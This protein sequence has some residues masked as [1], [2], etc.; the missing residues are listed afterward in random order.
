MTKKI[1]GLIARAVQAL[2]YKGAAA[3]LLN[4]SDPLKHLVFTKGAAF[5]TDTFYR[6]RQEELFAYSEA[7]L[8]AEAFEPGFGWKFAAYMRDPQNGK[9]NRIQGSVAAA[10]LASNDPSG[11]FTEEYT[12][13]CLR[14]RAD[15]L[16]IFLTHFYNLHLGDVPEAAKRGMARAANGMDEYQLL[17]YAGKQYPILRLRASGKRKKRASLRIVDALGLAKA[18]LNEQSLAIYN[19]LHA[20]SRLKDKYAQALELAPHRREFFKDGKYADA[21]AGRVTLEQILSTRGSGTL[22]WHNLFDMENV[23][24]D[25]AFKNHIRC[26]YKAGVNINR[27]NQ[28]ARSR[29]Y[30]GVYPHQ[31]FAGY[32]AVKR[33][34]SRYKDKVH[35]GKTARKL[36]TVAFQAYSY[37][38]LTPVFETVLRKAMKNAS[39][40]GLSLGLA[41][42]SPSMFTVNLAGDLSTMKAGDAAILFSSLMAQTL[43]YAGTFGNG[44]QIIDHRRESVLEFADEIKTI[45][46]GW[47]GTQVTRAVINLITI[48]LNQPERP[49]PT[50]IYF[51]TDMQFDPPE[52]E[53]LP[54][55]P[56]FRNTIRDFFSPH[57]PPLESAIAA[58]RHLIGE[59]DIVLWNLSSYDTTP[60]STTVEGVFMTSGFD[61]NTFK[62]ISNWKARQRKGMLPEPALTERQQTLETATTL[63]PAQLTPPGQDANCAVRTG[64]EEIEYIR[65]F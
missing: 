48:L 42:I 37:P 2:N 19:Y 18:Y 36:K 21:E 6:S 63:A 32:A 15:D 43:G 8:A 28:E 26:M 3:Y 4:K 27:I 64:D 45:G 52:I 56:V 35:L 61:I 54:P 10:I 31:V 25:I 53:T 29:K 14:H 1:T 41:D 12:Y 47:A 13:K 11:V 58:Y 40:D 44:I 38:E 23:L 59:V 7:L 55:L 50:T 24:S 49:R 62:H 16:V 5:F 65:G 20:P 57:K 46:R 60:V 51:F 30:T 17:K 22:V 39:L 34:I 9:G 33:G